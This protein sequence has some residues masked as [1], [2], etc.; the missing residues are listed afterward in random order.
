VKELVV[1]DSAEKPLVTCVG[2]HKYFKNAPVPGAVLNGPP[3]APQNL[4]EL[5]K[6]AR[7]I[8]PS[9]NLV[10]CCGYCLL[11]GGLN[12][13]P[14]FLALRTRAFKRLRVLPVP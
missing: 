13:R 7:E 12:L 5:E 6:W 10:V 3:L 8:P 11:A 4:D 9:A 14:G 2:F 1:T